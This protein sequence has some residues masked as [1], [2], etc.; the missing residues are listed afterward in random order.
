[1]VASCYNEWEEKRKATVTPAPRKNS[2]G[3]NIEQ[4]LVFDY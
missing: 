1:M 3:G 4:A 2:G